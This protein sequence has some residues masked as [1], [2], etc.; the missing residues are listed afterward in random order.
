MKSRNMYLNEKKKKD[1]DK[2]CRA[3]SSLFNMYLIHNPLSP[4]GYI[5]HQTE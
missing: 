5:M 1:L 3:H 4:N 2:Y